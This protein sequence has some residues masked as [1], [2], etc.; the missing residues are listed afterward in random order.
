MSRDDRDRPDELDGEAP[1]TPA[2]QARA[3]AFGRWLD[4]LAA[5]E[6][7]PPAMDSDDRAMLETATMVLASSHAVELG[8]ERTRRLVDQALENAVLGRRPSEPG[9]AAEVGGRIAA[10]RPEPAADR[11]PGPGHDGDDRSAQSATDLVRAR[12][13]RA[14]R[15]LRN[16]PWAVASLAAAAAV[17]LFVTRPVDPGAPE[18]RVVERPLRLSVT[19][20]SRPADPLIGIIARPDAGRA[21]ERLDVLLADRMEGYRD[22]KFR[23]ALGKEEP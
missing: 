23:R 3:E 19:N 5:G 22:L 18:A 10:L 9:I 6:P 2:E 12:R 7:L 4:G 8:P 16:L 13:R 20:T 11:A 14:D 21:S 17:V 15:V 1:V